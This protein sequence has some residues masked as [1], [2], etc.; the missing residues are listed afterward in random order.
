MRNAKLGLSKN[1]NFVLEATVNGHVLSITF[2]KFNPTEIIGFN[3]GYSNII[4][5]KVSKIDFLLRPIVSE[6][7]LINIYFEQW[8]KEIKEAEADADAEWSSIINNPSNDEYFRINQQGGASWKSSVYQRVRDLEISKYNEE[9]IL[10][11]A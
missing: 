11:I 1:G 10:G 4:V 2:N 3:I 6:S 9:S 7:E 5:D 8:D